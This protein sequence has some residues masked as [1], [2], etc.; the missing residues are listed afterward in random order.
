MNLE[1]TDFTKFESN[2]R[3]PSLKSNSKDNQGSPRLQNDNLF[4]FDIKYSKVFAKKKEQSD[5]DFF[6][7]FNSLSNF[8]TSDK[9]LVKCTPHEINDNSL[10]DE[11]LINKDILNILDSPNLKVNKDSYIENESK[12]LLLFI[13]Y[14]RGQ[15]TKSRQEQ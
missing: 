8:G 6:N 4:A 15:T 5:D 11:S 12:M 3:S 14:F 1:N 10:K 13:K 9:I 2:S 7:T